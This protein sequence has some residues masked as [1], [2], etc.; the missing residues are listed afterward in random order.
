MPKTES[1]TAND[2]CSGKGKAVHVLVTAALSI[3]LV[4]TFQLNATTGGFQGMHYQ[5]AFNHFVDC[6]QYALL[7]DALLDGRTYLDLPVAPELLALDDPYNTQDRIAIGSEDVPIF[8]DHAFYKGHY[9]CYFGVVPAVLVYIP[10]KLVTGMQLPTP[11]AIGFLGVLAIIAASLLI[12]RIGLRYFANSATTLSLA[13][14][15]IIMYMGSNVVYLCFIARFYSVP[16][17][18]SLFFTM[19][20]LWF[21]MGASPDAP[22]GRAAR[23]QAL[24]IPHLV[25][26]S[27]CMALNLGCRPQFI[28]A[29]LLAFIVFFDEIFKSRKLFSGS[30]LGA[31]VAAIVPF[32]VV[33]IP[34]LAYNHIRFGSLFDFGSNYNLTGFNMTNPEEQRLLL[35][36]SLYASYLFAPVLFNGSF[37][38]IVGRLIEFPE[39]GW[40]PTEPF[41][42]GFF[43]IKPIMLLVLALPLAWKPL[44]ERGLLALTLCC[45][46]FAAIVLFVDVRVAGITERYFSDFGMYVA[47][48]VCI[49]LLGLQSKKAS[50]KPAIKVAFVAFVVVTLAFGF[51]AGGLELLS[52]D[53]YDCVAAMNPSLYYG[54]LGFLTSM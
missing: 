27:A 39:L 46:A 2:P 21:W 37:S 13:T 36:A 49:I 50:Y 38:F 32:V 11:W 17:M 8:W 25:A 10:F 24:S 43:L 53:I 3:M 40:A 6:D 18:S 26:G 23:K 16:I 9:Y 51:I 31:T 15:L 12:R 41:F 48:A 7:A 22:G 44:R 20:G 33:F 45:L 29:C 4:L 47:L 1:S 54:T 19:L 35:A 30:G 5:E 42:G 28:L 14:C 34:L 52:P